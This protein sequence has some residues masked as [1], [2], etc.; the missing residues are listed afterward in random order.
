MRFYFIITALLSDNCIIINN[1]L[2]IK[3]PVFKITCL[4]RAFIFKLSLFPVNL[5]AAK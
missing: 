4:I 2:L 5:F 3:C 1:I